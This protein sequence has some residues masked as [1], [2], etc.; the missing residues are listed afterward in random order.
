MNAAATLRS[1]APSA[2]APRLLTE[3]D[4]ARMLRCSREKV[5]KLRRDG[6]LAFIPSRPV[7][8]A[9]ADLSAY[10]DSIKIRARTTSPAPVA[11]ESDAAADTEAARARARE[12]WI[13]RRLTGT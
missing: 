13:K 1:N 12:T 8:I 7:M 11:Q 5:R 9:E 6:L 10:L 2:E 4:V 3:D